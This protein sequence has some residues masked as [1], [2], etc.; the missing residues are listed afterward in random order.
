MSNIIFMIAKDLISESIPVVKT[1]DTGN[2]AINWMEVH[3][4][5][6]LPIV[7]NEVF[8]GLISDTD[9]YDNN[10]G[11]EPI[12]NHNLSLVRPYVFENQHIFEIIDLVAKLSI[13]VVPVL[14]VDKN[15]WVALLCLSL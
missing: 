7:N 1:S 5:S 3:R 11:D 6:H 12:G 13:T 14:D 2:D 15:I 8:L 10:C 9:I 4:V